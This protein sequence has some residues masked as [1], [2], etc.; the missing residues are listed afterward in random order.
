MMTNKRM[1]MYKAVVMPIPRKA[2]P[3]TDTIRNMTISGFANDVTFFAFTQN[4]PAI[5]DKKFE[6]AIYPWEP[7]EG[8][9]NQSS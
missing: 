7:L 1:P 2:K 5:I 9:F 4:D 3:A 6:A 8:I